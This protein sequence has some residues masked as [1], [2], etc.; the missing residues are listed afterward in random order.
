MTKQ[1][2]KTIENLPPI[3]P[4]PSH[5]TEKNNRENFHLAIS[6]PQILKLYLH[7]GPAVAAVGPASAHNEPYISTWT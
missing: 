4:S 3:P 5:N 6:Y 1:W 7:N 2:M